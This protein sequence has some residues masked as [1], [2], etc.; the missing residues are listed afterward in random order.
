MKLAEIYRRILEAKQ[1]GIIYHTMDDDKFRNML[2]ND[3][4]GDRNSFSRNKDYDYVVGREKEFV[5]QIEVDGD[6]LSERYKIS[7]RND[8]QGWVSDEFEEYVK[9]KI[10]NIGKYIKSIIIIKKKWYYW[11]SAGYSKNT[12]NV[13]T[14]T[15][16]DE[17]SDEL[18]A[19]LKKYPSIKLKV[20]ENYGGSI[21]DVGE[22]ELKWLRSMGISNPKEDLYLDK[23]VGAYKDKKRII[24]S[25]DHND[26]VEYIKN[27]TDNFYTYNIDKYGDN[28]TEVVS[29]TQYL[30]QFADKEER[31]YNEYGIYGDSLTPFLTDELNNFVVIELKKNK[32]NTFYFLILINDNTK[33]DVPYYTELI[34]KYSNKEI[35]VVDENESLK[36]YY[37]ELENIYN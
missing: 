37:K 28:T 36:N 35:R 5:Y 33:K 23:L 2:L 27:N 21:K 14:G 34:R 17:I 19:Y 26:I 13:W 25:L 11:K 4:I 22:K 29:L 12:Y 30:D 16:I 9:D 3:S 20:K 15:R 6:K 24:T 31:T 32:N 18:T 10:I 7:P 8:G 1:V